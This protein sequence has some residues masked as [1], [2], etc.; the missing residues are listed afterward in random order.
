DT[1]GFVHG[2]D[3]DDVR[4]V[5]LRR[6]LRLAQEA[7][8]D[9]TAE[10]ELWRQDLDGDRALESAILGA[11]D[12]AH[13]AAPD[14]GVQFVVRAEHALDVRAQLGIGGRNGGIRQSIGSGFWGRWVGM[15]HFST[16]LNF[17][18]GRTPRRQHRHH[19]RQIERRIAATMTVVHGMECALRSGIRWAVKRSPGW[20]L[21][22][23]V[24]TKRLDKPFEAGRA[25]SRLF[26]VA[27]RFPFRKSPWR[28]ARLYR[29]FLSEGPSFF[30]ASQPPLLPGG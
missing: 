17:R 8:L 11:I 1:L 23:R 3:V 9:L 15:S 30:R 6:G 10:C 12:H 4:V 20:R 25:S 27:A 24:R 16:R 18:K 28:L 13:P 22:Q 14:L 21:A 19:R 7:S 5:Q 2:V 29:F 26:P